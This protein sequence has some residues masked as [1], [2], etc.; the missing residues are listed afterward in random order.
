MRVCVRA[1]AYVLGGVDGVTFWGVVEDVINVVDFFFFWRL[2]N[3]VTQG[4]SVNSSFRP[5][6]LVANTSL[7]FCSASKQA[8]SDPARTSHMAPIPPNPPPAQAT[9]RVRG[10]RWQSRHG[11]LSFRVNPGRDV[12]ASAV[13][14]QRPWPRD[15]SIVTCDPY[16]RLG[17]THQQRTVSLIRKLL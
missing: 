16:T 7:C 11:L 4:P 2:R 6:L 15:L 14:S 10:K 17:S 12:R 13:A 9:P 3:Q 1:R 5:P 8:N